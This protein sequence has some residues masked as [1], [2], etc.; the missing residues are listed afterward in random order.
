MSGKDHAGNPSKNIETGACISITVALIGFA[1][2]VIAAAIGLLGSTVTI[3]NNPSAP[4]VVQQGDPGEGSAPSK[5]PSNSN[6]TNQ[7]QPSSPS[8]QDNVG[9]KNA[10]PTQQGSTGRSPWKACPMGDFLLSQLGIGDKGVVR[11]GVRLRE[12]ASREA[13]SIG[14]LSVGEEFEVLDGVWCDQG[15][16][17]WYVRSLSSGKEGFAVEADRSEYYLVPA[18]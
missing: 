16:I 17:W 9:V 4:S 2:L 3:I 13:E 5:P 18:D 8:D 14:H 10:T 6:N 1:G 15:Y 12:A 7:S 11:S